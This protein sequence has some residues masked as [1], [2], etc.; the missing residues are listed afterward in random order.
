[1]KVLRITF[2]LVL[3]SLFL[4]FACAAQQPDKPIITNP[5]VEEKSLESKTSIYTQYDCWESPFSPHKVLDTWPKLSIYPTKALMI[6]VIAG[7]PKINWQTDYVP[8]TPFT[9]V[10]VPEGEVTSVVVFVFGIVDVKTVEL[11]VFGY[12]DRYD[13]Y[14]V[15]KLDI[16]KECYVLDIEELQSAS[17]K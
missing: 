2:L 9:S 17:T 15:Y 16:D 8:G 11:L 7:N 12:Q 4:L 14:S 6:M 3:G 1:M 13:Q 10:A 5:V